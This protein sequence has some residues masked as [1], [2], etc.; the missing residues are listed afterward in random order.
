MDC[1]Y[2]QKARE[3]TGARISMDLEDFRHRA[4]DRQVVHRVVIHDLMPYLDDYIM[5]AH[6]PLRTSSGP[7]MT[8]GTQSPS[9][10]S[11]PSWMCLGFCFFADQHVIQTVRTTSASSA[12]EVAGRDP[13]IAPH[14]G[15]IEVKRHRQGLKVDEMGSS[16]VLDVTV[17][18]L[19]NP[20]CQ[21][22]QHQAEPRM[23][24][25]IMNQASHIMI[26][27]EGTSLAVNQW[28]RKLREANWTLGS[29]DDRHHW[30]GERTANANTSVK[31]LVDKRGSEQKIWY[32][33]FEVNLGTTSTDQQVWRPRNFADLL[34]L[35]AHFQVDIMGGDFNAFSYRYFKTG[36]QRIAAS[37]QDSPLAAMLR[38]FDEGLNAQWRD[39]CDNHPEYQFRSDLYMAYRDADIKE[40]RLKRDEILNEVTDAADE[41]T[42]IL[43]LQRALQE[44]D[45][46]F[47]V[48]GL[49][50]FN[51]G[52]R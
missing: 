37:L 49:V 27:I 44:Y 43:R 7:W 5:N 1:E 30:P 25:L 42:K 17:F 41:S 29:S 16:D 52:T 14:V 19:G 51:W 6:D 21:T 50:S 39:V 32:T 10:R 9:R 45:E 46:N 28:D 31:K 40:Y 13:N 48:I 22:I 36:S 33:V 18:N 38:R 47:D 11:S 4:G 12:A 26:F 34:I 35:C 8:T 24:R 3:R 15:D 23:L 20:A 2:A